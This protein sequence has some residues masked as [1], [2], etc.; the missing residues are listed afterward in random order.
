M[1]QQPKATMAGQI[2]LCGPRTPGERNGR[3]KGS[4]P[5]VAVDLTLLFRE[6]EVLCLLFLAGSFSRLRA[7]GIALLHLHRNSFN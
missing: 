6:V 1:P 2:R 4:A 5:V 3:F 7:F